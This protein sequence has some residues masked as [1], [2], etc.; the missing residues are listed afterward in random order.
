[1]TRHVWVVVSVLVVMAWAPLAPRVALADQRRHP[2]Q[3]APAPPTAE[4]SASADPSGEPAD[5]IAKLPWKL[6]PQHV[7]LGHNASLDLPAGHRFLGLPDAA[8]VM[9]KMGNLSNENLLGIAVSDR[10][11]ADYLVSI[12]YEEEGYVKDDDKLDA[13]ELL[14]SIRSGEDEYNEERKKRGFP[15]I[16]AEGWFEE[17]VYDK[18]DHKLMWALKVASTDGASINLST[19]ILGRRGYV[20]VTLIS[21]PEKIAQYRNDGHVWVDATTFNPGSRYTDFNGATDKVAKYGLAGLILAGVGV[22]VVKAAKVGLVAA[23]WKP[24]LAGLLA[25]KK[26]LVAIFVGIGALVKKLFGG[27]KEGSGPVPPA[28]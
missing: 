14:E 25:L 24:L 4:P 12:R 17:P 15:P 2:S 6:G 5:P 3:N 7:D 8:Q 9:E 13:K 22:G 21:G 11:D 16:H 1:M 26:G 10:E 23:F 27:K 28:T 18:A 19:R 20:S